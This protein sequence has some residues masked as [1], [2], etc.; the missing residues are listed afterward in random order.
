M[1][2]CIV[3]GQEHQIVVMMII[4]MEDAQRICRHLLN[5]NSDRIHM[6]SLD[7]AINCV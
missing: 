4:L 2:V 6:R 1:C 3:L 7:P 5:M